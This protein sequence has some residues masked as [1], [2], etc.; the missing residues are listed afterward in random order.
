MLDF[1]FVSLKRI[2]IK[3]IILSGFPPFFPPSCS[4]GSRR[5]TS[6]VS[7]PPGAT[8]PRCSPGAAVLRPL[9][10]ALTPAVLR[11]MAAPVDLDPGSPWSYE[12]YPG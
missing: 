4:S 7:W 3:L 2:T 12:N 10:E 5:M 8:T 11:D 9:F 6:P 1:H